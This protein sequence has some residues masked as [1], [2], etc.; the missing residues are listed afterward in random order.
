MNRVDPLVRGIYYMY[1][2]PFV[3]GSGRTIADKEAS[4]K[5]KE[6]MAVYQLPPYSSVLDVRNTLVKEL[7]RQYELNS[8]RN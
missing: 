5:V 1:L 6:V 8:T 7:L 3:W 2:L 4:D